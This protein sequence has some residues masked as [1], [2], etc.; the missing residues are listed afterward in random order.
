MTDVPSKKRIAKAMIV[1]IILIVISGYLIFF[2]IRGTLEPRADSQVWKMH[3]IDNPGFVLPNGLDQADV[4]KDGY[5]DYLTNYEFDERIRIA[6]HPGLVNVTEPWPALTVGRF[7][8]AE[9]SAFGDFDNDS[10]VDVVVAHGE[11]MWSHSG[12][13]II[14]GPETSQVMDKTAWVRSSDINGTH[15]AGHFHY[16][17]SFDVNNDSIDDIIVGGRGTNPQAGLKWIEAPSDP[18]QCREITQWRVHNIDADLESGH[19]FELGDIDQDGDH[20][21]VLCNSDWD[22]AEDEEAVLWYENPGPG[23]PTQ[24]NEWTKHVIYQGSEFYTKEQVTLH[25]FSGDGYPEVIMQTIASVYIFK[26]PSEASGDTWDLVNVSKPEETHWR[27][28]PIK[29][30]DLNNDTQPDIVGM[31][32][33]WNGDLPTTKAAVYWMEFSGDYENGT[34]STHVIKWGDGFCGMNELNGEKWDQLIFQDIDS[35]GDWDIVAN[36]E[37]YNFL[38]FV[39]IAVVWFENPLIEQL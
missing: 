20:D 10:N 37:E 5:L 17:R 23:D 15:D 29:V 4:N 35:D 7:P 27:A 14:W 6:F 3:M 16:I 8:N 36:C 32:I 9:S 30:G 34:W 11:E 13:A 18:T 24:R 31:L 28:R 22:T 2:V 39:Y 19:G 25:D 12:I 38:G 21:I 33:H 26:N 1:L